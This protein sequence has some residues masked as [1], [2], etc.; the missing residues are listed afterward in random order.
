MEELIN[1]AKNICDLDVTK[2]TTR[3]EL[4]EKIINQ[5]EIKINFIFQ[6]LTEEEKRKYCHLLRHQN[7]Y[8]YLQNFNLQERLNIIKDIAKHIDG[9]KIYSL[10][11]NENNGY[12][13]QILK[14]CHDKIDQ[15]YVY[16]I[17]A[18]IQSERVRKKCMDLFIHSSFYRKLIIQ[19]LSEKSKEEYINNLEKIKD[20]VDVIL[21]LKDNEKIKYYASL[22][23]YSDYRSDLVIGTKDEDFIINKFKEIKVNKFR[24]NLIKRVENNELRIKLIKMLDDKKMIDFLLT[25]EQTESKNLNDLLGTKISEDITIGIE[26]ECCNKKI[27]DYRGLKNIFKSYRIKRDSSVRKG[28]EI[29]SPV[30]RYT[31]EDINTLKNVCELLK[32]YNFYTDKTCGGHIHIGASYLNRRE[33]F[34]ML[35]YLYTNAEDILYYI[36]DKAKTIKRIGVKRYAS[37]TKKNYIKAVDEG[38]FDE[39]E[40]NGSIKDVFEKVN[41]SRYKGMNLKN[42]G[43]VVK[44]TI[45]FRMPNGEINFEELLLNIKLFAR[46]IEMSHK[47]NDTCISKEIKTKTLL[48]AETKDEKERLE[49][50]LDIL[51]TDEEEKQK[52]RQRYI[53]NKKIDLMNTGN[54]LNEIKTTLFGIE[55]IAFDEKTKTLIKKSV[56]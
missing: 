28:F 30:I 44:N 41:N 38:L 35:I 8:Y 2:I 11:L 53:N 40:L 10:T 50:F 39:N 17:I 48:L 12:K 47:L 4:I 13:Y 16:K 19:T 6:Y 37:K 23:E 27:G 25:N 18:T 34:L 52:Y 42:I 56:N 29:T 21:Q 14:I 36:S 43:G 24:L 20:K 46:L 1:Y 51:F 55:N 32:K 15:L 31:P 45:E 5:H 22:P 49:L 33:D 26:L 7:L 54:L 3:E 9:N